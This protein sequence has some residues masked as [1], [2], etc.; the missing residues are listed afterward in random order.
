ML[1]I[2]NYYRLRYYDF[3]IKSEKTAILYLEYRVNHGVT[4]ILID[5]DDNCFM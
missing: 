3:F 5:L 1:V 4:C 2:D